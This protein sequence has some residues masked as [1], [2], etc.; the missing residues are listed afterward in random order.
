[1]SASIWLKPITNA[2]LYTEKMSMNNTELFFLSIQMSFDLQVPLQLFRLYVNLL[3]QQMKM[4]K[5]QL[6]EELGN[7]SF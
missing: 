6:L 3:M 2:I 7:L 5:P 1:M 4:T